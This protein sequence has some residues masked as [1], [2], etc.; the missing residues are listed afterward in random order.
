MLFTGVVGSSSYYITSS[1]GEIAVARK[2]Y[3]SW[4]RNSGLWVRPEMA[5]FT[6]LKEYNKEFIFQEL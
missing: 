2:S 5:E 3:F 4:A 1:R 6:P